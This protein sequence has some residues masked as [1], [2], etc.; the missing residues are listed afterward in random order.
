LEQNSEKEIN[1]DINKEFI[2]FN[3]VMQNIKMLWRDMNDDEK[4]ECIEEFF[5]LRNRVDMLYFI[6]K[7][8]P[9][10]H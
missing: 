4:E 5:G 7:Y 6:E 9:V 1:M 3:E 10:K 2:T 8:T